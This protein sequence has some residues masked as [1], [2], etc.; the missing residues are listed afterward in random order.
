SEFT[1]TRVGSRFNYLLQ[2]RGVIAITS[3][4]SVPDCHS[5]RLSCLSIPI[6]VTSVLTVSIIALV[7]IGNWIDYIFNFYFI[8]YSFNY[9]LNFFNSLNYYVESLCMCGVT[10]YMCYCGADSH[11]TLHTWKNQLYNHMD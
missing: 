10:L 6:C 11:R 9:N 4:V 7:V 2:I 1:V 5:T 8:E 3:V